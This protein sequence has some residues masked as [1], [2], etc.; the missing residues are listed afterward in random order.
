MA[1]HAGLVYV[2][3]TAGSSSVVGF[4]LQGGKLYRIPGSLRRLSQ[5][6]A[7]SASVA[8]SP[9]GR[10]LAVTERATNLIDVFHVLADGTLSSIK[11]NQSAGPGA[12]AVGFAPN[13]SASGAVRSITRCGQQVPGSNTALGVITNRGDS[14]GDYRCL[15]SHLMK[16]AARS[17]SFRRRVPV[18]SS[19]STGFRK[20]FPA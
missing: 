6:G 5:N 9:D 20:E 10:F 8:F 18:W 15:H 17:A 1:E 7:N 11:S 14:H 12:F 2:L 13:L 3:N 16:S 4:K 19:T